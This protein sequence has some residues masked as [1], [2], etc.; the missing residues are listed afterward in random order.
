MKGWGRQLLLTVEFQLINIEGIKEKNHLFC[1][2]TIL[3]GKIIR[4]ICR[5]SKHYSPGHLI[6]KQKNSNF[7]MEKPSRRHLN[8]VTEFN[9]TSNE[10]YQHHLLPNRMH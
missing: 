9:I 3:T 6:T 1:K 4:V 5:V 2:L 7:T 10:T 8:Q